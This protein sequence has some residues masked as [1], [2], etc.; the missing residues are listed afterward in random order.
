MLIF[1]SFQWNRS[2]IPTKPE[3]GSLYFLQGLYTTLNKG[4]HLAHNNSLLFSCIHQIIEKACCRIC[5]SGA[6]F[7]ESYLV[8]QLSLGPQICFSLSSGS[9]QKKVEIDPCPRPPFSQKLEI[10]A[11]HWQEPGIQIF[12]FRITARS[13]CCYCWLFCQAPALRR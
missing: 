13:E 6:A 2:K 11:L 3:T 7:P 10:R 1:C 8:I 9:H 4:Q 12:P 5:S